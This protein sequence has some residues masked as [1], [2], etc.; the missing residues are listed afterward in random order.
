[1]RSAILYQSE[2]KDVTLID[3]PTSI[4]IAQGSPSEVHHGQLLS[5]EPLLKPYLSLEPKSNK[6]KAKL[7]KDNEAREAVHDSLR[8]HIVGALE[9]IQKHHMGKWCLPRCVGPN[10]QLIRSSTQKRKADSEEAT[11]E[12][13]LP[14]E[15]D[16]HT[17]AANL[18]V[19]SHFQ[20]AK[21]IIHL[22]PEKDK[23][24]AIPNISSLYNNAVRNANNPCL[25]LS[26]GQDNF[27]IPP[28]STFIMSNIR[29]SVETIKQA[30]LALLPVTTAIARPGQFNLII[31]DPPWFNFSVK[32]A[33][34]YKVNKCD[35]LMGLLSNSALHQHLAYN[36]YVGIWITNK[37]A[38]RK[39]VE[40]L[41]VHWKVQ[42]I[43]EWVWVKTTTDGETV[44]ELDGLWRKPYEIFCLGKK[45]S[46]CE[47]KHADPELPKPS[48][49]IIAA[50]PDLHSRK[51]CLKE[52][53]EHYMP[54]P[55]NYQALEIFARNLVAGWWSWG[56]EVLKFNWEGHWSKGSDSR[57]A[58]N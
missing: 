13:Q 57:E 1:M 21:E 52:L 34:N 46:K 47:A 29:T 14:L 23:R 45:K 24:D 44:T 50:V 12:D 28:L 20:S 58:R 2:D 49:K 36:G 53:L 9:D 8:S 27:I 7:R 31:I 19:L 22:S 35:N 41:F 32:R 6:A 10:Q 37:A 4:A 17:F 48:V 56:D 16:F 40:N 5:S 51:P 43:E 30:A 25:N 39:A 11:Q 18:D 26:I 55:S 3:I 38:S 15:P 42:K 33:S 54:D